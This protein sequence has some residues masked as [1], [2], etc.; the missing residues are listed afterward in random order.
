MQVYKRS[1]SVKNSLIML[2]VILFAIFVCYE[3]KAET[4]RCMGVR[5]I[6]EEE[7]YQMAFTPVE[8]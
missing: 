7:F 3:A 2:S 4:K 8:L 6:T 5:F 1:I